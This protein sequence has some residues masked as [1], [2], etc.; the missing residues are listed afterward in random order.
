LAEDDACKG[1][2]AR[3]LRELALARVGEGFFFDDL[4]RFFFF[5]S[6]FSRTLVEVSAFRDGEVEDAN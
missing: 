5:F 4:V 6:L 3:N 2:G 1:V